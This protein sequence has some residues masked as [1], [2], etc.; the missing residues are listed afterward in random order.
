MRWK[1]V[2]LLYRYVMKKHH[3]LTIEVGH[4][5]RTTTYQNL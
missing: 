3:A 4:S 2:R 5:G 1:A